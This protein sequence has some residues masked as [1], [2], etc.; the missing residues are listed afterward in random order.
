LG[1]KELLALFGWTAEFATGGFAEVPAHP[2]VRYFS[3]SARG[4][5]V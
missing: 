3:I 1:I 2:A 4:I 5:T